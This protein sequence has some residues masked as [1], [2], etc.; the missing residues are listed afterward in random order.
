MRFQFVLSKADQGCD[1]LG[2][3]LALLSKKTRIT[4]ILLANGLPETR[5]NQEFQIM[6]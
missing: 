5:N 4:A 1:R 3:F 6:L 2:Q